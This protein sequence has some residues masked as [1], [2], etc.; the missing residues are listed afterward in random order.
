MSISLWVNCV[1]WTSDRKEKEN[2]Y[3]YMIDLWSV[4]TTFHDTYDARNSIGPSTSK[5]VKDYR[6]L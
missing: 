1:G 6:L 4:Y 5:I 2:T 3:I